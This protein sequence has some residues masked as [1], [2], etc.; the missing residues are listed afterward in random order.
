PIFTLMKLPRFLLPRSLWARMLLLT[1]GVVLLVQ[2]ATIATLSYHRQK[3]TREVAVGFTATS[4]STLRAALSQVPAAE[5][6]DFVRRASNG[7]WRLWARSLPEGARIDRRRTPRHVH[8]RANAP[9]PFAND[10]RR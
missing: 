9:A 7:E 5:R 4:L 3:F 2:G 8:D 10:I 1:L 6:A